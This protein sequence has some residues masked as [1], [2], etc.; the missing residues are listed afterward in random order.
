MPRWLVQEKYVCPGLQPQGERRPTE[1]DRKRERERKI[2]IT[3]GHSLMT[4]RSGVFIA[5]LYD[6]GKR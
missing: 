3:T 2:R 5:Y 4:H 6:V 1:I